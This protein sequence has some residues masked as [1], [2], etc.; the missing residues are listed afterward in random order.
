MLRYNGA[1]LT[2]D[3]LLTKAPFLI[4]SFGT[5]QAGE[6][7]VV[8]YTTGQ[9]Y[10]FNRSSVTG[11]PSSALPTSYGL[12]QNFP[13]PFNQECRIVFD[14]P[15]LSRVNLAVY[16]LLGQRVRLLTD[17]VLAPGRHWI[18]FDGRGE[19]GALLSSGI[20]FYRLQADDFDKSRKLILLR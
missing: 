3:S 17:Q 18:T 15:R 11:V 4:S 2:A 5:D 1:S 13:N 8:S 19:N 14:L 10:R 12:E 6:L 20:Y 16:N 9:I 7:Y